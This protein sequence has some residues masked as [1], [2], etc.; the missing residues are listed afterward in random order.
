MHLALCLHRARVTRHIDRLAR[1]C[2]RS[3][4]LIHTHPLVH[5]PKPTIAV[6]PSNTSTRQSK[7]MFLS[8]LLPFYSPLRWPLSHSAAPPHLQCIQIGQ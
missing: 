8:P 1:L 7:K 6:R 5:T 3:I 4:L 2:T